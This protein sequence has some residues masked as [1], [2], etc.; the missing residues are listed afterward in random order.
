MPSA[1]VLQA[2]L[3]RMAFHSFHRPPTSRALRQ[4]IPDGRPAAAGFELFHGPIMARLRL[5]GKL[6]KPR[7]AGPSLRF[8]IRF[9]RMQIDELHRYLDRP[10]EAEGWLRTWGLQNTPRAH[11]N[12][13]RMADA[14]ITLDLLADLCDQLAEH[15]PR[16]SDP[17]MA[18]NNLERF[19]LAAR[20]P[21]SLASLFER[22][23]EA[24]P[25]LLEILSTS[26]HL[27]DLLIT[28]NE[29][30]DLL[31]ITEGQPVA[32]ADAGR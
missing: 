30:Y 9:V 16:T 5:S 4:R 19:V 12:L 23:R 10:A 25:V 11:G 32:R 27:A 21:L 1:Q 2:F 17:D 8:G 20:N 31:R 22:D 29:A 26:Q 6:A 24:L 15:L 14:G 18:L 3:E 7:A 28:D 13:V